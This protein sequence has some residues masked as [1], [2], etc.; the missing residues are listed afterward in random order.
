M[1]QLTW[2][3][4]QAPNLSTRDMAVAG[5]QIGQSFDR[6]GELLIRREDNLRKDATNSAAAAAY[7]AGTPEEIAALRAQQFANLDPRVDRLAYAQALGLAQNQMTERLKNQGEV[8]KIEA[9]RWGGRFGAGMIDAAGDGD[10]ARLD[11]IRAEAEADPNAKKYL[12]FVLPGYVQDAEGIYHNTDTRKETKAEHER[13]AKDRAIGRALEAKT[14]ALRQQEVQLARTERQQRELGTNAA[15]QLAERTRTMDKDSA[16]AA[17]YE[18]DTFKNMGSTAR[19]AL[20]EGFGAAHD[21]FTGE[22]ASTRA[23][24]PNLEA[25]KLQLTAQANAAEGQAQDPSLHGLRAAGKYT[26]ITMSE[27]VDEISKRGGWQA[28]RGFTKPAIDKILAEAAVTV[29]NP[30]GT[31]RVVRPS[32]AD[33]RGAI[34]AN[35]FA[36]GGWKNIPYWGLVNLG[37]EHGRLTG[38]VKKIVEQRAKGYTPN[39]E[40]DV[41]AARAPFETTKK[42]LDDTRTQ[43]NRY[44]RSYE[45]GQLSPTEMLEMDRLEKRLAELANT[46]TR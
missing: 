19:S 29:K 4:I 44:L 22:T 34:D 43:L 1:A 13:L 25:R 28:A 33:I 32:L 26:D 20:L 31:T 30:D 7:M 46:D 21:A 17:V 36:E 41:V 15:L 5:N 45:R 40:L 6:L 10:R 18:S 9:Q 24:L 42:E 39:A 12:G 37:M 16:M 23:G 3:E 14:L 38:Q 35:G 8:D 11:T 27:L 2:R